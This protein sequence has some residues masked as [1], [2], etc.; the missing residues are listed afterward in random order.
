MATQNSATAQ[1]MNTNL[2]HVVSQD[3]ANV[4]AFICKTLEGVHKQSTSLVVSIAQLFLVRTFHADDEQRWQAVKTR[5]SSRKLVGLLLE[6]RGV[7]RSHQKVVVPDLGT[8]EIT[9]G[10]FSPTLE[11]SIAFAR[12]PAGTALQVQVDIRGKLLNAA[13]PLWWNGNEY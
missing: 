3:P 8:G 5:D 6:D 7:L 10:T 2:T 1:G 4:F 11:R 9:S 12:V 13:R